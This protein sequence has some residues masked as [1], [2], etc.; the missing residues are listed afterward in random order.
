[1]CGTSSNIKATHSC[2]PPAVFEGFFIFSCI[3]KQACSL[4]IKK[5]DFKNDLIHEED[6][7]CLIQGGKA[8][9]SQLALQK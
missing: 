6:S 3:I 1:M 2:Q 7:D 4:G 9:K 8:Q 5:E